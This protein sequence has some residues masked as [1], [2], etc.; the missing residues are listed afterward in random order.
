MMKMRVCVVVAL[1]A[2]AAGAAA[3]SGCRNT[4]STAP[5][6][7]PTAPTN[8]P[9][10]PANIVSVAILPAQ[11]ILTLP[12]ETTGLRVIATLT[13]GTLDITSQAVWSTDNPLVATVT[14]NGVV[15]AIGFGT[16]KISAALPPTLYAAGPAPVEIDVIDKSEIVG[17]YRL[18]FNASKSCQLPPEAMSR[19]YT[20]AITQTRAGISVV[21]TGATFWKAPGDIA[22][23]TIYVELHPDSVT[24]K[25]FDIDFAFYEGGGIAEQFADNEYLAFYG[26]GQAPAL[27]PS[28]TAMFAGTV[29]IVAPPLVSDTFGVIATCAAPDHQLVFRRIS[30]VSAAR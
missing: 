16:A 21:L 5:T 30:G 20:A 2:I 9:A 15:T 24:F 6:N 7:I 11:S 18:T 3:E 23:N 13:N 1:A 29:S 19:T 10:A 26:T 12:G 28:F 22:W 4:A 25:V 14:S 17:N 27:A 8:V